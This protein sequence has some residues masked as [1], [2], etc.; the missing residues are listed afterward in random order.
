MTHCDPLFAD[1]DD[2]DDDDD[3]DL[4]AHRG[5]AKSADN[6]FLSLRQNRCWEKALVDH[7][8]YV[9]VTT[10]H[11][12]GAGVAAI[13]A[14][15]LTRFFQNSPAASSP[16]AS[17]PHYGTKPGHFETSKIHFP[18]SEGVSEVSERANE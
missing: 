1:D 12:L 5:I 9:V 7:P 14:L 18:M 15:K 8:D 3:A 16:S 2:D 10:G 13:L 4:F 11:S 6:L 17:S